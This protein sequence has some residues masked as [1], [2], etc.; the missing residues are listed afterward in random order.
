MAASPDGKNVYVLARDAIAAF[1]R[2]PGG[3]LTQLPGLQGCLAVDGRGGACTTLPQLE[4]GLDLSISP[5]GLTLYV[6][7]YYPGAIVLLRRDPATGS[8]GC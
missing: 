8:L 3:A 2:G 5:D 6:P 7:S 1:R 4:N